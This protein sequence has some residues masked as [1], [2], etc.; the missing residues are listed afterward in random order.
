MNSYQSEIGVMVLLVCY[1]LHIAYSNNI[2]CI[3][4]WKGQPN[5]LKLVII[6][7]VFILD[8]LS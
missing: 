2:I 8:I 7:A 1:Y 6:E 5:I 3:D 4:N